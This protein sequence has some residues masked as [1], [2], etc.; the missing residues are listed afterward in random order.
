MKYKVVND[1]VLY[2]N[3]LITTV[4]QT[5]IDL[6]IYFAEKNS[7]KRIRLCAHP[8]TKDRLHEMIIVHAKGAYVRPHKHPGKSESFHIIA[9]TLKVIVFDDKGDKTEEIVMS[10][11]KSNS[12][13][14]YRLSESMFHTVIPIS[15]WVVFHEVTNGPFDRSETIFAP[16]SPGEEEYEKQQHFLE[17]HS[18]RIP[19][20]LLRG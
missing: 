11:I 8:N 16:W 12:I 5:D 13:F 6:L 18:K 9:G 10:G 1:E 14:Y 3:E 17:L 4:S 19:R 15:E 7:R 20:S 2:T